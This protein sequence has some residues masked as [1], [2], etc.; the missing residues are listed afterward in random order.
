MKLLTKAHHDRRGNAKKG[1][2]GL[3][4]KKN[5]IEENLVPVEV[6]SYIDKSIAEDPTIKSFHV[7]ADS[8]DIVKY[9][10]RRK[11]LA[12]SMGVMMAA[13]LLLW[14]ISMLLTQWGDLIISIESPAVKKGIILSDDVNFERKTV[15]LSATQVRDVTNIT[16]DWLPTNLDEE[17]D[18][19]HNGENYVAYTFYCK[20]SGQVTLDYEA[21]LEITGVA[22]SADE[23]VRVMVYKNGEPSIYG[24]G[25]YND[26]EQA[27][28]DCTKF[29]TDTTVMTTTTENFEVDQVDKYTIV[30]WVEGEDPE[31]LD[32][33]RNG[34]VRMRMLFNVI[35]DETQPG[36]KI[37]PN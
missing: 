20:N 27:E 1:V 22:K 29:V 8:A 23:A 5:K 37:F 2:K 16:Y 3:F 12:I 19:S 35:E 13:L 6:S 28:T 10:R 34:H 24:K 18:G 17:A 36:F 4:N 25:Q 14:I 15:K 26:R 9:N 7:K 21:Y 32:D 30:I 33:I 11:R 31:C